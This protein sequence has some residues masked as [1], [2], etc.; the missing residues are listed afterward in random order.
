MDVEEGLL[1]VQYSGEN[2][3]EISEAEQIRI[4]AVMNARNVAEE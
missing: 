4:N 1:H 2:G 3:D